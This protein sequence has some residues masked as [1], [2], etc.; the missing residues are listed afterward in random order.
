M[1]MSNF[2]KY[3]FLIFMVVSTLSCK[4]SPPDRYLIFLHSRFLE[5]NSITDLH[6]EHGSVEYE[7]ILQKFR[8]SGLDVISEIREGNTNVEE[9]A[10]Q[11][12]DQVNQLIRQGTK[13]EHITVAGTS[14]GGYIAQYVS[15]LAQNADL[16][17]VFIACYRDQDMIEMPEL[18]YC[19]NI[20]TIYE[21]TDPYGVSAIE[22]YN[23]STCTIKHFKEIELDNG[24]GHGFIFKALDEWIDPAIAWAKGDFDF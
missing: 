8:N 23:T 2:I 24:L 14:K 13:P 5:Q 9:Y 16:N 18:H 20:L 19:G 11:V 15:N 4:Q 12:I 22:R 10:V 6:P 17:Y 3:G 7:K 21:K 1:I